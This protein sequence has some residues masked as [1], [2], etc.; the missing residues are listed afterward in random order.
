VNC[1]DEFPIQGV[2]VHSAHVEGAGVNHQRCYT[3]ANCGSAIAKCRGHERFATS[4]DGDLVISSAVGEDGSSRHRLAG[5]RSRRVT[6]I[7]S[8][9]ALETPRSRAVL[10]TLTADDITDT[11]RMSTVHTIKLKL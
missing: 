3:K 1:S 11:C 4:V 5:C 10:T 2:P 8:L 6:A 9:H 7:V